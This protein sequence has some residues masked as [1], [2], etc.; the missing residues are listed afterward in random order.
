MDQV[1]EVG[2]EMIFY[3]FGSGW[4]LET[5][6]LEDLK[7]DIAY[8]NAKIDVKKDTEKPVLPCV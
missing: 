3:S 7:A 6:N 5:V 8:A 1:H 4:N 2:F